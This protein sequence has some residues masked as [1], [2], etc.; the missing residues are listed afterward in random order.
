VAVFACKRAEVIFVLT[1]ARRIFQV[2]VVGIL[3]A[4]SQHTGVLSS[5][6]ADKY[7]YQTTSF[8]HGTTISSP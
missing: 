2:V 7:T 1:S 6:G 5:A 4:D 3:T 8:S